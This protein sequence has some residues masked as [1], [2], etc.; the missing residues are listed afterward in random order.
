M[1]SAHI[2]TIGDTCTNIDDSSVGADG[3]GTSANTKNQHKMI[4]ALSII[5]PSEF[6]MTRL[7][8][9]GMVVTI[10]S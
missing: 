1:K 6:H 7:V 2:N 5:T 3:T 10:F 8:T 4:I 9:R